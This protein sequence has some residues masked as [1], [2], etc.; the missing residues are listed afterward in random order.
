MQPNNQN[1]LLN[2]ILL[3][4]LAVVT[5]YIF[6]ETKILLWQCL[7]FINRCSWIKHSVTLLFWIK[8]IRQTFKR[9]LLDYLC[10]GVIK[11]IV[12]T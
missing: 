7:L 1:D 2:K 8:Y 12:F 5:H 3:L 10:H 6:S 4:R 11:G 9:S